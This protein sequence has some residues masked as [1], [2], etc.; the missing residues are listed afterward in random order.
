[1][2]RSSSLT[3]GQWR[4]AFRAIPAARRLAGLTA[5]TRTGLLCLPAA[6]A[7]PPGMRA[8]RGG[9][10]TASGWRHVAAGMALPRT[11]DCAALLAHKQQRE[12]D[13]DE[14]ACAASCEH[15]RLGVTVRHLLANPSKLCLTPPN[16][17]R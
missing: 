7:S 3:V 11:H 4:G 2:H 12:R 9:G 10:T 8:G 6:T 13:R 14:V 1:M 15:Q 17:D 5:T 16:G